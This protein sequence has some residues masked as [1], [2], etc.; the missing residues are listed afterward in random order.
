MSI[1]TQI[2]ITIIIIFCQ[3]KYVRAFLSLKHTP[4]PSPASVPSYPRYLLSVSQWIH[5]VF[6]LHCSIRFVLAPPRILCQHQRRLRI[7]LWQQKIAWMFLNQ[8]LVKTKTKRRQQNENNPRIL[9]PSW[10]AYIH[11]NCHPY[12]SHTFFSPLLNL[13]LRISILFCALILCGTRTKWGIK[14]FVTRYVAAAAAAAVGK[15]KWN[16]N[17]Q[18]KKNQEVLHF[19]FFFVRNFFLGLISVLN[20]EREQLQLN[21]KFNIVALDNN[22]YLKCEFIR[23]T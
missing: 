17:T 22:G 12:G 23:H 8:K 20:N 3:I 21:W 16:W 10:S 18:R 7:K 19:T 14:I 4:I 9:N 5:I 2:K 13:F 6:D 15:W 11:L 1:K